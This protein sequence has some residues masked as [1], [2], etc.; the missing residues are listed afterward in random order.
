M[1]RRITNALVV[2]MDEAG[3]VFRG[4]I[5]ISGGR[6]AALGSDLPPPPPGTDVIDAG[7]A[8]VLPGFVNGH[9]HGYHVLMRGRAEGLDLHGWREDAWIDRLIGRTKRGNRRELH[10]AAHLLAGCEQLRGGVTFVGEFNLPDIALEAMRTIGL[11][12]FVA[13][14]L[15]EFDRI[16]S[17]AGPS[18]PY[19]AGIYVPEE[20]ELE[21][22]DLARIAERN[23]A[24]PVFKFMHAAETERR[25]RIVRDRF[26]TDLVTLLD[27][28][29]LLDDRMVLSHAVHVR[30][31]AIRMLAE[32]GVRV[33]SSVT[34]EMKLA[35]GIAPVASLL[36]AGVVVG[37]GTDSAMC[38]NSGDLFG[39]MK[40][41]GLLRCLVD[42]PGTVDAGRI[43]RMATIDGA[44]VFHADREIGSIERGKRADLQFLEMRV[45]EMVPLVEEGPRPN[46][47]ANIVYSA[48]REQVRDVMIDGE[49][50]LRDR[51]PVRV[52]M[53]RLVRE[54]DAA[55]RANGAEA[56]PGATHGRESPHV[57]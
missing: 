1:K 48:G 36:E 37:V 2:T 34:S 24:G 43:L 44:R 5:D 14:G 23:A 47:Y 26:G 4:E 7:G 42:G 17:A 11:R 52:D 35:D 10:L 41:M 18:F 12:G 8:A 31:D 6:I 46:L 13:C 50:V 16:A 22:D 25:V 15:D 32:R 57:T 30:A 27:K 19:G 20:E 33:V 9:L 39:E 53:D 51:R 38:N 21:A 28:H 3:N 54:I 49:F 55:G 40:A 45:P 56:P 29:G